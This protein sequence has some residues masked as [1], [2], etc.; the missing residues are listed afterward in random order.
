MLFQ[1]PSHYLEYSIY[2]GYI[3]IDTFFLILIIVLLAEFTV[4][5]DTDTVGIDTDTVGIDTDTV[6][7]DTDAVG[8]D[9]IQHIRYI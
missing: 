4:D 1:Y 9:Y 7:I 3:D 2:T 6:G 5:I 8:I